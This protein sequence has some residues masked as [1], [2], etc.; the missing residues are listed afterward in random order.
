[1]AKE[2]TKKQRQ[3]L[4][5]ASGI[6][7]EVHFKEK[8]GTSRNKM[9]VVLDEVYII[10]SDY[11]HLIQQIRP[12]TPYWDGSRLGYRTCY[13]TFDAKKKN[14]KFGQYTQFLTQKEYVVLL[15]KAKDK[16]WAIFK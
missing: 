6:D 8:G 13:Y 15:S 5:A 4:E 1:M 14:I 3:R 12:T 16:G 10:V 7:K 11:K 2:M 9:G